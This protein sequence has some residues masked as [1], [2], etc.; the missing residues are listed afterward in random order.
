MYE[1]LEWNLLPSPRNLQTRTVQGQKSNNVQCYFQCKYGACN[2]INIINK[3]RARRYFPLYHWCPVRTSLRQVHR[4][5]R[6]SFSTAGNL[7]GRWYQ[8]SW[9]WNM[10]LQKSEMSTWITLLCK[11]RTF[12]IYS[13][14][15]HPWTSGFRGFELC[16][17]TSY[18]SFNELVWWWMILRLG[19]SGST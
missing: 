13:L 15:H 10:N 14:E 9:G 11:C 16:K 1:I 12:N 18:V 7:C 5:G 8:S 6:V 2:V 17:K 4:C 3:Q 19:H